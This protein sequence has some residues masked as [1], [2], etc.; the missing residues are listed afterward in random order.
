MID[1]EGTMDAIVES[2]EDIKFICRYFSETNLPTTNKVL[3]LEEAQIISNKGFDIVSIYQDGSGLSQYQGEN[4]VKD[5]EKAYMCARAVNQPGGSAIYF[6]VDNIDPSLQQIETYI[7]PYFEAVK[8]YLN[9]QPVKYKIGVYGTGLVC[10]T[11]KQEYGLAD[12]S[13]L[14]ASTGTTGSA[15]Y[16]DPTLYD[17]KQFTNQPSFNG[18]IFDRDVSGYNVDFGQW[19]L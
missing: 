1:F 4:L 7:V 12:Y 3:E 13:W 18:T 5:P 10:R 9:A 15:A 16:N 8:T 11:I 17:I 14:A 19:S 2:G 6:S